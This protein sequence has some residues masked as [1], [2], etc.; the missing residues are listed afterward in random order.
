MRTVSSSLVFQW[1]SWDPSISAVSGVSEVM[2][3]PAAWGMS[4][5]VGAPREGPASCS[6]NG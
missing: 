6:R 1:R 5:P 3:S 4:R 2:T